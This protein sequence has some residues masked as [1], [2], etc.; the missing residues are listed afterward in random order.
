MGFLLV[1]NIKRGGSNPMQ[2]FHT[3]FYCTYLGTYLRYLSY[4]HVT[5]PHDIVRT[6]LAF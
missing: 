1:M 2:T 3:F 4:T 6:A 5:G